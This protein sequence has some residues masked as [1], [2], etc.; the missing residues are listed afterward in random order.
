[1][2]YHHHHQ[3]VLFKGRSFNANLGTNAA[4]LLKGRL[5]NQSCSFTR[6]DTCFRD[7]CLQLQIHR[8]GAGG[9]MHAYHAAGP[10]SISGRDKFPGW[11]FFFGGF[12]SPIRQMLGSFRPPKVPEYHLAIIMIIVSFTTENINIFCCLLSFLLFIQLVP[13]VVEWKLFYI[14]KS[15][16]E[17]HT[18]TYTHM[19]TR[20]H[21]HTHTHTHTHTH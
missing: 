17:I 18:H 14:Y 3:C 10:G 13:T 5:R 7:L 6:D 16:F 20:T 11:G 4:F 15:T 9:S 8:C 21:A 19:H 1:M 2:A 12:S